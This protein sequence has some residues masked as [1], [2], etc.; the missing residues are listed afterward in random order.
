MPTPLAP[1]EIAD[2]TFVIH[3][4]LGEGVAPVAVPINAMVIRAAEPV[5]VDTGAPVCREQYLDDLFSIVAPE[6]VRWVF[7]SHEDIDHVGNLEAV[8]DACPNA[9][10]I[11]SWFLMERMS[12]E[13]LCVPP[14]RWRWIG[15]GE[16]FDVGDRVLQAVRPPL[17][18]S[19]TTRGLFDPTTRVYWGSDCFATPV[20]RAAATIDE[21]DPGF[22]SEGFA[23]FQA[24]NSPWVSLV[25]PE[26]YRAE[27][28]RVARLGIR[29]VAS[30]HSPTITEPYVDKAFQMLRDMPLAAAHVPPQPGQPVLDEIIASILGGADG[31]SVGQPAAEVSG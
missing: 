21:L 13:G 6:D 29:T 1:L 31:V 27:V 18:D 2:E 12:S 11:G 25:D 5:L 3:A 10:I 24:Y 4:T 17:Y 16:S 30:C 7:L 22:W 19:P 14:M 26:R 9:T 23:M 28:E 15:D 8:M 20:L